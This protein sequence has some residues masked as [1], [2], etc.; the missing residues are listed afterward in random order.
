VTLDAMDADLVFRW[1]AEG[2]LPTLSHLGDEGASARLIS[3]ADDFPDGTIPTI[4]TGC[5][6]GTHGRY[7]WRVVAPGTYAMRLAPDRTLR[8][9]YWQV[10]RRQTGAR[11][12][13]VD[14]QSAPLIREEGVTQVTGWGQRAAQRHESWP[15]ELFDQL[16]SRHGRPPQWLDDD[17]VQ[18]SPRAEKRY[19]RT[20]ERV[21]KQRPLLLRELLASRPWDLFLASFHEAHNG[22]HVFHRYLDQS[23]WAYDPGRV[24]A[25]GALLKIY[26]LVDAGLGR[27]LDA[28]PADA[29]VVVYAGHGFRANTNGLRALPHMLERLGYVVPA[30]AAPLPRFLNLVA[31]RVPWSVRRYVNRRLPKETQRRALERMWAESVDWTRT[32]AVAETAFG[33]SFVRVN[34]RGREPD[35]IVEPGRDHAEVC[36]AITS[37]LLELTIPRTG[38]RAVESVRRIDSLFDGPKVGQLPDLLVRWSADEL[39]DELHHPR[40]GTV[41]EA[42]H[43]LIPSEHAPRGFVLARGPGI[44]AGARSE[45]AEVDIAPTLLYLMGSEIPNDMDGD[46]LEGLIDPVELMARPP[47]RAALDWADDPWSYGV[48]RSNGHSAIS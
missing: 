5:Y 24:A 35:G 1:A 3:I 20:I 41:R 14:V 27:V 17:L 23:S 22:G 4:N 46:V 30:R 8:L 6:P 47:R 45:G 10:G 18:R 39:V 42:L 33:V 31:D 21:A 16:V 38:A 48:G 19:F 44:R 11:L 36:D 12:V 9:P 25:S 26:R 7:N 29:T 2:K 13:L 28:A 40:A 15:P 37:D 34:L 43:D 32:R